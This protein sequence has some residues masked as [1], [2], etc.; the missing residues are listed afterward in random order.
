MDVGTKVKYYQDYN[1]D[2]IVTPINCNRLEELLEE[3]NYNKAETKFLCDGFQYRFDLCYRGPVNRKDSSKNVP[4]SF[5]NPA[6][7][8]NKVMDEV[9]EG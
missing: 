1:W 4:F 8:W 7:F 2:Q 3:V 6:E 5:G 9:K